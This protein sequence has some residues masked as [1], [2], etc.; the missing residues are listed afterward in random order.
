M[1]HAM[2]NDMQNLMMFSALLV[3][4][5]GF[6]GFIGWHSQ[7]ATEEGRGGCAARIVQVHVAPRE[8]PSGSNRTTRASSISHRSRKIDTIERDFNLFAEKDLTIDSSLP[9]A[10]HVVGSSSSSTYFTNMIQEES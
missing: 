1:M 8:Q 4:S 9:S 10:P 3:M 2:Q 7:L 5:H 6:S